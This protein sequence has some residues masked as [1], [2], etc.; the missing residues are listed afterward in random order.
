MDN[1]IDTLNFY[2]PENVQPASSTVVTN[3]DSHSWEAYG[4]HLVK[5]FLTQ[6]LFPIAFSQIFILC[7]LQ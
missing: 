6:L 3:A 7:D 5:R 4:V 2:G 1:I